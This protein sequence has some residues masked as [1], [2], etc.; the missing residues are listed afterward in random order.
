MKNVYHGNLKVCQ[1]KNS[2][3]L[4]LLITVFLQRLNGTKI[5]NFVWNVKEA[6]YELAWWPR[7]LYSDFSLGSCLFEGVIFAE[8]VDPD[9]YVYSC[10]CIEL[11]THT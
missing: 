8:N 7:D 3:L 6:V 4:S 5:Q 11:D 1:T 9:I 10:Y 2:L